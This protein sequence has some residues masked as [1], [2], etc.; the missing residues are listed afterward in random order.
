[1]NGNARS[2]TRG[3]Q[4]EVG[5]ARSATR[6]RLGGLACFLEILFPY[7]SLADVALGGTC[8]I[9]VDIVPALLDTELRSEEVIRLYYHLQRPKGGINPK[10][11]EDNVTSVSVMTHSCEFVE[12]LIGCDPFR[13]GPSQGLSHFLFFPLRGEVNLLPSRPISHFCFFT[14]I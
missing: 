2:V 10:P 5:N 4:R 8:L 6:G 12:G 9:T 14:N 7:F 3:R 13:E 11:P 1:M